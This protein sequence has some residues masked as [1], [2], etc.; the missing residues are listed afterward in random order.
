MKDKIDSS[1]TNGPLI[2]IIGAGIGGV[3][4]ALCLDKLG[5]SYRIFDEREDLDASGSGMSVIGH[6]LKLLLNLGVDIRKVGWPMKDVSLVSNSKDILLQVPTL[7]DQDLV[8]EFGSVQ[9]NVHRGELHKAMLAEMEGEVEVGKRFVSYSLIQSESVNATFEDGSSVIGTHLI[10]ADGVRS[11]V[12]EVFFHFPTRVYSGYTCWRGFT[13]SPH[14]D[15]LGNTSM[16]HSN[17]IFNNIWY[18]VW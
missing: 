5:V 14:L 9:F 17:H 6:S 8:G 11:R 1:P 2:L 10:G 12:R 18:F 7:I 13:T 3:A 15:H 16:L 4:L